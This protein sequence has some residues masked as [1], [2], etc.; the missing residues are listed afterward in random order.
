LSAI[1]LAEVVEKKF[2]GANRNKIWQIINDNRLKD[3][4]NYSAY[5]F[6]NKKH[7]DEYVNSGNIISNTPSIYNQKSVDFII[8]TLKQN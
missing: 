2:S 5:N 4:K 8:K 3:D 7:E 6:S 1:E